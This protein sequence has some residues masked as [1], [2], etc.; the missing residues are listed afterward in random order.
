VLGSAFLF[1]C[2]QDSS[3]GHLPFDFSRILHGTFIT[4]CLGGDVEEIGLGDLRVDGLA[5]VLHT[6]VAIVTSI[7]LLN[8]LI[9]LIGDSYEMIK[10]EVSTHLLATRARIIFEVEELGN[11]PSALYQKSKD[12]LCSIRM[13]RHDNEFGDDTVREA[14]WF[15]KDD[16]LYGFR[17]NLWNLFLDLVLR[18]VFFCSLCAAVVDVVLSLAYILLYLAFAGKEKVLWHVSLLIILAPFAMFMKCMGL[19]S[20]FSDKHKH[21]K[22]RFECCRFGICQ[23]WKFAIGHFSKYTNWEA[24]T[25]LELHILVPKR[26]RWGRKITPEWFTSHNIHA[27]WQQETEPPQSNSIPENAKAVT[28][29]QEQIAEPPQSSSIPEF[30]KAV[31]KHEQQIAEPPQSS[32]IPELQTR[33]SNIENNMEETRVSNIE[34]NTEETLIHL[35]EIKQLKLQTRVS[36]ME[37]N[38][39]EILSH[40]VEIKQFVQ[41]PR[42]RR[43]VETQRIVEQPY[44]AEND[45]SVE[46]MY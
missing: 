41:Q 12:G 42:T 35:V 27:R 25:P 39:E 22:S 23:Y 45:P 13:N 37:K 38:M 30:A 16:C 32:S 31:T 15:S 4:L 10:T 40:L 33:V 26:D 43:I 3:N 9:A 7:V 24:Q 21:T 29:H 20:Y 8:L 28:K 2:L 1:Y 18:L 6:G 44:G 34:N 11:I 14:D 17:S 5:R 46:E 19:S 36:N